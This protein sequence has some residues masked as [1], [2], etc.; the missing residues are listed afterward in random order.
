MYISKTIYESINIYMKL[1][2]IRISS[3]II[4]DNKYDNKTVAYN[5]SI[6]ILTD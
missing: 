1:L 4:N 3:K 2:L 6:Y 5:T